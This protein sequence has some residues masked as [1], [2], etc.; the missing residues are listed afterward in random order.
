[1]FITFFDIKIW[2]FKFLQA[3]YCNG[4]TG[5][6]LKTYD[7]VCKKIIIVQM[8]ISLQTLNFQISVEIKHLKR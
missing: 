7:A 2:I 1:M 6:S 3:I 5:T 8:S 4:I